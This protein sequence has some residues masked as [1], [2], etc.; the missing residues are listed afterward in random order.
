MPIISSPVGGI[1]EVVKN[2]V[3][4]IIVSPG[5]DEEICSAIKH[6]IDNKNLLISHGEESYKLVQ[7]YLPNYVMNHL[8]RIYQELLM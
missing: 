2:G 7:S 3:N 8:N 1:P 5:N 6:Y 4:G